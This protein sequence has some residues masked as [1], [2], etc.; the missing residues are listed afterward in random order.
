MSTAYIFQLKANKTDKQVN[1]AIIHSL[2][3]FNKSLIFKREPCCGLKVE[4][5][6]VRYL[7]EL[8]HKSGAYKPVISSFAGAV[9]GVLSEKVCLPAC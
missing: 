1:K 9:P 8:L 4:L 7:Y 5:L 2:L 6:H 3:I